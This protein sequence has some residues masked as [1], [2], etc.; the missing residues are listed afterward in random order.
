MGRRTEKIDGQKFGSWTVLST[1]FKQYNENKRRA[2][3]ICKCTCGI[4][5]EIRA[6]SLKNGCSTK[7][8]HCSVMKHNKI[9]T[10][11]YTTWDAMK[12]RCYNKKHKTYKN[13]GSRGI[14][15][16]ERW[17]NSFE[18]FYEDMGDKPDKTYSL[19]RI[20]VNGNYEPSNCKWSTPK[21]QIN[22]R[23]NTKIVKY[24][25]EVKSLSQFCE[26]LNLKYSVINSRIN[27]GWSV[28][29]AFTTPIKK[30]K[31]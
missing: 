21:E 12:T 29:N 4:I 22:N 18:N 24:N 20:D 5:K 11:E 23:R 25:G 3:C 27:L 13:Y 2:Y 6:D 30:Y 28:E 1:E 16:C 9:H 7:C 15:V 10:S 31:K 8:K 26:E 17:L 19:D 14:T